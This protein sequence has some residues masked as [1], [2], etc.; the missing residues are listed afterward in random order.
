MQIQTPIQKPVQIQRQILRQIPCS[1]SKA[2]NDCL[3]LRCLFF[4]FLCD[5][6]FI[7]HVTNLKVTKTGT[8]ICA[9]IWKDG[10]VLGADTRRWDVV[11]FR[12]RNQKWQMLIDNLPFQH[13]RWHCCKQELWE[14]ALHVSFHPKSEETLQNTSPVDKNNPEV[15]KEILYWSLN[16][17]LHR[18][19]NIYCAGAGTAAD[20]DKTT[21]NISRWNA[22]NRHYDAAF[23]HYDL[24][25]QLMA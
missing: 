23:C 10:V 19:P 14:V 9:V 13:G 25:M 17:L 1:H 18:A 7:S 12:L 2:S 11:H 21:A 22:R 24:Q 3:K 15:F 8:T 4:C 6:S 20:C 5:A 16:A